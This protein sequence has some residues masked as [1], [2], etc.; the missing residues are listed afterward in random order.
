MTI[1]TMKQLRVALLGVALA[2]GPLCAGPSPHPARDPRELYRAICA[3]C[4]GTG[5]R[6]DGPEAAK[7]V[8]RPRN[9][10][11]GDFKIRSTESGDI[12]ADHDLEMVIR[13][14][15]PGTA[16]P[17]YEGRLTSADIEGLRDVIKGFSPRFD[18]DGPG[19]LVAIGSSTGP[20]P[21]A[22]A[23]GQKLFTK[24]GCADCHGKDG[25]GGGP[26]AASLVDMDGNP[27]HPRDLRKRATYKGG[28]DPEDIARTLATGLDGSPMKALHAINP[29]Q[30][31][32]LVWYIRSISR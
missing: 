17:A 24:L 7:L 3:N 10:A 31:W 29:N 19:S 9:F 26:K 32:P 22:V 11:E 6:G 5:G 25:S 4:H 30:R 15:M 12:P 2:S 8:P 14:G 28:A 18:V 23:A 13:R 27:S 16:M 21:G 20:T 1:Q